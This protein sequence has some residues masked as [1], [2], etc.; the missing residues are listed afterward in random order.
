MD[1]TKAEPKTETKSEAKPPKAGAV[2]WD[3][4]TPVFVAA[5][6]DDGTYVVG[7]FATYATHAG[8]LTAERPDTDDDN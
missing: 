2:G 1:D 4:D 7:R 3:G 5:V 8:S 6:N